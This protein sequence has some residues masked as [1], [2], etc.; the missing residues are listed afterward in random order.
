MLFRSV[1][2]IGFT[3]EYLVCALL[4]V[5][6]GALVIGTLLGEDPTIEPRSRPTGAD[7]D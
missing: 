4:V 5:G 2:E 6:A 3:V 7:D 1:A